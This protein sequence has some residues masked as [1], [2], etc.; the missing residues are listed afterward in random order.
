MG[1]VIHF[2]IAADDPERAG[3]F[4]EI[5]GWKI[6]DAGMPGM[7][8]WLAKTGEDSE[9]GIDG[10]IMPREYSPK[11]AI[12]NTISVDDLDEMKKKVVD[13][14]GKVDEERDPIPGVGRY[15]GATD[16]EGNT[17][18]MLQPDKP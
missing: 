13:A 9:P 14:G 2:E 8:Y 4:Y 12:R 1:R 15:V 11:Q 7:G 3:K 6:S 5:F 17:F 10:A 16:T 18:G